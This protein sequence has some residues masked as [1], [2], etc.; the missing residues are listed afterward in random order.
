MVSSADLHDAHAIHAT[1]RQTRH[2]VM[3]LVR[4]LRFRTLDPSTASRRRRK[5]GRRR[6]KSS[7]SSSVAVAA[8]DPI[9]GAMAV[10]TLDVANATAADAGI[11]TCAPSNA[12]NHSVVVHVVRGKCWDE[13]LTGRACC[14]ADEEKFVEPQQ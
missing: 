8:A 7:S 5:G 2:R 1:L 6:Q 13:R 4:P 9:V 11:Y 12:R 3:L 14:F 10:S